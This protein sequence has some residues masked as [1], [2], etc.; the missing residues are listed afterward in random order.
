MA[1]LLVQLDV[2]RGGWFLIQAVFEDGLHALEALG[3]DGKSPS[4]GS[5]HPM[6][7]MGLGQPHD[8]QHRAEALLGMGPALH[9]DPGQFLGGWAGLGRPV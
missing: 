2:S 6:I 3:I 1:F 7:A 5:L 4:A 8:A 9:D